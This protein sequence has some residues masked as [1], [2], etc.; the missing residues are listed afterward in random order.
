MQ[1]ILND[2]FSEFLKD[3]K[4]LIILIEQKE[5]VIGGENWSKKIS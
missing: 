3:N 2:L 5:N 4:N 1:I